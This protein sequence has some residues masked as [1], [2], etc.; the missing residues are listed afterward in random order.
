MKAPATA[1][2]ADAVLV[3]PG[4]TTVEAEA[5]AAAAAA[6]ETSRPTSCQRD[7]SASPVV[8]SS[9]HQSSTPSTLTAASVMSSKA[10]SVA[11][12]AASPHDSPSS[13]AARDARSRPRTDLPTCRPIESAGM[14]SAVRGVATPAAANPSTRASRHP[15]GTRGSPAIV[16]SVVREKD[17]SC[18]ASTSRA[19]CANLPPCKISAQPT[20]IRADW[21]SRWRARASPTRYPRDWKKKRL[22]SSRTSSTTSSM[23]R[24][25]TR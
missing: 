13:D 4:S 16:R 15:T 5:A 10:S 7:C 8:G 25:L 21:R 22:E 9:S 2:A 11:S 23:P 24:L 14:A 17:T 1:A 6:V 20:A 12:A 3:P 19:G 18:A